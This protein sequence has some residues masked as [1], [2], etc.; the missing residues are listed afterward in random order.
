MSLV[1]I[2][3]LKPH[4]LYGRNFSTVCCMKRFSMILARI[5]PAFTNKDMHRWLSQSNQFPV[6]LY[7][8]TIDVS[9]YSWGSFSLF[10]ICCSKSVKLCTRSILPTLYISPGIASEHL[11]WH[12][13]VDSRAFLVSEIVVL[14]G[15]GCLVDVVVCLFLWWSFF[16]VYPVLVFSELQSGLLLEAVTAWFDITRTEVVFA[17]LRWLSTESHSCCF[18]AAVLRFLSFNPLVFFFPW[19][20]MAGLRWKLKFERIRR[21][22]IQHSAPLT[23]FVYSDIKDVG[24]SDYNVLNQVPVFSAMVHPFNL[25]FVW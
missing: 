23:D 14:F 13:A 5:F 19:G 21:W 20:V 2:P 15:L 4:S 3:F 25:V 17:V 16:V 10:Q 6:L 18:V 24:L 22:D 12:L 7:R 1:P 9:L 8:W 11:L